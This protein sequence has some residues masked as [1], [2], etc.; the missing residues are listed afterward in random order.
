MIAELDRCQ[1]EYYRVH[2]ARRKAAARERAA[3]RKRGTSDAS[4]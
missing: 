3:A 1:A 4:G 2:D